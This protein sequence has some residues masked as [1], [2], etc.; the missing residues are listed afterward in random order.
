MI[1]RSESITEICKALIALSTEVGKIGKTANNPYFN[2][3]YAPLSA[4]QEAIRQP[5]AKVG[6]SYTQHPVDNQ[7]LSTLVMHT[8]GEWLE[9]I[10][11]I[12]PVPDYLKEKDGKEI[13]WRSNETYFTPQSIGSAITYAKRYALAAIFALNVDDDDDGNAGSKTVQEVKKPIQSKTSNLEKPWLNEGSDPYEK[14]IEAFAKGYT[15]ADVET[16]Y[17]ISKATRL[18]LQEI[19]EKYWDVHPQQAIQPDNER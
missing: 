10:Y 17:R 9:S 16:K 18:K 7:K 14:V 4:I 5:L 19:E 1:K 13:I 3:K 11:D 6:L 8:S 2:S 12:S 15:M